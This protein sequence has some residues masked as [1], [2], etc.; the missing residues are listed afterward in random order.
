[1]EILGN[2]GDCNM[3][4]FLVWDC[5]SQTIASGSNTLTC[6][7]SKYEKVQSFKV[8]LFSRYFLIF[9][10]ELNWVLCVPI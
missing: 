5:K 3:T 8:S 4:V 1:M 9:D 7:A 2:G 10:K 6:R